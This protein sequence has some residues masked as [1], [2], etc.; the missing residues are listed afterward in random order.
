MTEQFDGFHEL[1][2]DEGKI[3]ARHQARLVELVKEDQR[4]ILK[5]PAMAYGDRKSMRF[6]RA[7]FIAQTWGVNLLP[8]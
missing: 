2:Y 4:S 7:G 3:H 6:R 8:V 5:K 1:A